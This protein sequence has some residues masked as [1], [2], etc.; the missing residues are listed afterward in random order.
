MRYKFL[1]PQNQTL[2]VSTSQPLEIETLR[3]GQEDFE[4]G[5]LRLSITEL[6]HKLL[7]EQTCAE[8]IPGQDAVQ[9]CIRLPIAKLFKGR[10]FDGAR[11]DLVLFASTLR[12]PAVCN[13]PLIVSAAA[14]AKAVAAAAPTKDT[15]SKRAVK[16]KDAKST[17]DTKSTAST[18]SIKSGKSA[19]A[20]DLKATQIKAACG[21]NKGA[22]G[23]AGQLKAACS[24]CNGGGYPQNGN[25]SNGSNGY[26]G[27]VCGCPR[28]TCCVDDLVVPFRSYRVV[29]VKPIC[30]GEYVTFRFVTSNE[31]LIAWAENCVPIQSITIDGLYTWFV[32]DRFLPLPLATV[33]LPTQNVEGFSAF[34]P[35]GPREF[36][37]VGPGFNHCVGEYKLKR[38]RKRR[39]HHKSSNSSCSSSSSSS[40]S[41]CSSSSKKSSKSSCTS[42]S[43]TVG[44]C[45]SSSSSSCKKKKKHRNGPPSSMVVIE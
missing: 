29:G 43:K 31:L 13:T 6:C 20:P 4:A 33:A 42:S 36:G 1:Q 9:F 3:T 32:H 37:S 41:S 28:P 15:E 7:H 2:P 8:T 10:F 25:G 22:A 45:T 27:Q 38:H 26:H 23:A 19:A 21:C 17:S 40:S 16:S 14:P 44:S 5:M 12:V 24:Q 18:G 34:T 35:D 11:V 39:P 30:D